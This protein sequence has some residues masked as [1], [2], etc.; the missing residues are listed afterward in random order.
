MKYRYLGRTGLK[1][2][3]LS[4]GTWLN[5]AERADP[6]EALAMVRMALEAGITMFDTAEAYGA[7]RAERLLGDVL[8]TLGTPRSRYL[9]STKFFWGSSETPHLSETLNRKYLLNSVNE[10]LDRLKTTHIDI[11]YCHRY[12]PHIE[13]AELVW[14]MSDIVAAG[15]AVWWGTSNWPVDAILEAVRT[16]DRL[17]LRPPVIEQAEYNLRRRTSV[18]A[19]RASE[20]AKA[21]IGLGTWS[22]LASGALSGKYQRHVP[23]G[24]RGSSWA[25]SWLRRLATE[26]AASEQLEKLSLCAKEIGCSSAQLAIAWCASQEDVATVAI[27]ART[28]DQLSENIGA[29]DVLDRLPRHIIQ[30]LDHLWIETRMAP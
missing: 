8:C 29:I 22:P 14:T 17:G 5:F 15:K 19:Y 16:A 12:D 11:V 2:S 25:P 18:I 26:E 9:L 4:Y 27:G 6:D 23:D 30:K 7:G 24:S 28:V 20:L 3:L 1:I 13:M 10:S 21:G